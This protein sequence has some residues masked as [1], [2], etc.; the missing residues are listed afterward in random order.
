MRMIVCCVAWALWNQMGAWN[1]IDAKN[2]LTCR[3]KLFE[4][5][6][7]EP[8]HRIEWQFNYVISI[9][10]H[11]HWKCMPIFFSFYFIHSRGCRSSRNILFVRMFIRYILKSDL[12]REWA[13]KKLSCCQNTKKKR[14]MIEIMKKKKNVLKL[15]NSSA[16]VWLSWSCFF[17][18]FVSKW[19]ALSH[20]I[21]KTHERIL[22]EI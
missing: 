4:M 11:I 9:Y 14:R 13:E 19:Y 18:L 22:W 20:F 3:L 21:Q 12:D 6:M 17:F 10:Y 2:S 1:Q 5:R 16:Q 7:N 8:P 15:E